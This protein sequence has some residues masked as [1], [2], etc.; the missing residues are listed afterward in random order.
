M[1]AYITHPDPSHPS[2]PL[3]RL[4]AAI[5]AWLRALLAEHRAAQTAPTPARRASTPNPHKISEKPRAAEIRT[6]AARPAPSR[7]ALTYPH[8]RNLPDMTA[9]LPRPRLVAPS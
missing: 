6:R 4:L 1:E 7:P 9:A 2:D 8:A 5:L 3:T